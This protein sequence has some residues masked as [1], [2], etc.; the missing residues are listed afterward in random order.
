MRCRSLWRVSDVVFVC[1]G[2]CSVRGSGAGVCASGPEGRCVVVWMVCA[3]GC[4]GVEMVVGFGVMS[5]TRCCV[6]V[7]P[8]T[9][10]ANTVLT[11]D[12]F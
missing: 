5:A 12:R 9:L 11:T 8:G 10:L 6:G 4:A 7:V 3:S 1:V 2:G